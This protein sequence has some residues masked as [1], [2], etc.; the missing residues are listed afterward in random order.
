[1]KLM[2]EIIKI[3]NLSYN[4]II[5]SFNNGEF[6]EEF[7]KNFEKDVYWDFLS[8]TR[9]LSEE[10]I[11]KFQDKVSWDYIC[12]K[13]HLSEE[14]IMKFRNR[15]NW[16]FIEQYQELTPRLRKEIENRKLIREVIN[17]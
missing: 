15:V 5:P 8:W 16:Y 10:F 6:T 7:L 2:Q 14:F 9:K 1:M 11:E 17:S 4:Q 12:W 3:A 13:Q